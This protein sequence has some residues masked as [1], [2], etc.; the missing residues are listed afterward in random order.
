MWDIHFCCIYS[1]QEMLMEL[2]CEAVASS[3]RL[4]KSLVISGFPRDLRQV[5]SY[6]AKVRATPTVSSTNTNI[7]SQTAEGEK[8]NAQRAQANV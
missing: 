1:L 3:V 8:H 6:E 5:E 4:G 2:L 7:H